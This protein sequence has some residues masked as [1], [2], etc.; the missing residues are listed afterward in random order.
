MTPALVITL[1]ELGDLIRDRTARSTKT[2]TA[3]L[4]DAIGHFAWV[5]REGKP[6]QI[7]SDSVTP[8]ETVIVY[9]GEQIPID[10]AVTKGVATVDE[11]QLTGESMPIV[12]LRLWYVRDKFISVPTGW[13]KIL[14]LLPVWNCCK[15]RR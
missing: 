7:T 10:G 13:G 1:H 15:M 6:V 11:Q 5:L 3:N 14:V 9:P 2:Q 12:M 8:G 4:R